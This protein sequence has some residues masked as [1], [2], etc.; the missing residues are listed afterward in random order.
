M[1]TAVINIV[2]A[3]EFGLPAGPVATIVVLSTLLS[4]LTLTAVINLLGA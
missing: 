1:P 4:P 2:L 3:T